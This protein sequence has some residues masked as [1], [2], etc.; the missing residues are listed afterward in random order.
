M[1][2]VVLSVGLM[3]VDHRYHHLDD[4]R[5]GLNVVVDPLRYAINLP[6]AAGTWLGDNLA[7]RHALIEELSELRDRNLLLKGQLQKY[8]ALEAEN[9]RLREL[10]ESS[11]KVGDRVLIA[12]LLKVDLEPYTRQIVINKGTRDDVFVGQPL[13]DADGIIGQIVHVSLL[14]STAMLVTDPSHALPVQINRNGLRAIAVGTGAPNRLELLHIPNNAEIQENDLLVTSG[15]GGRFPAGYPVAR[16]VS[17]QNDPAQ[18]FARVVAAPTA[19]MQRSREVLLVWPARK[20]SPA[21]QEQLPRE[22]T[23]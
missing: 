22:E 15:L 8:S 17:V 10:L 14:S 19:H 4:I 2:F 21:S 11:F 16:V 23:S 18:P 7:S 13:V 12:E 9:M 3:I 1:L 20:L 6:F 5:A